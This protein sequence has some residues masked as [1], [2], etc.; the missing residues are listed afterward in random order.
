MQW[1]GQGVPPL[2][3]PQEGSEGSL[4]APRLG[5]SREV[6]SPSPLP[7][8]GGAPCPPSGGANEEALPWAPN[9][10]AG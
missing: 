5:A 1:G 10:P 9:P 4:E 2:P 3:A 6:L 7:C 8:Q